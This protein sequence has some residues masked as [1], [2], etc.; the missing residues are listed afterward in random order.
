MKTRLF[1]VKLFALSMGIREVGTVSRFGENQYFTSPVLWE[2]EIGGRGDAA[3]QPC[4]FQFTNMNDYGKSYAYAKMEM[5]D[6]E[7]M[8]S[9]KA[10]FLIYK[11]LE[12]ADSSIKRSQKTSWLKV[13]IFKLKIKFG[14]KMK[15]LKK[16]LLVVSKCGATKVGVLQ[17]WKRLFTARQEM[18]KIT[19]VFSTI[20]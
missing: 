4:G 6:P 16:S 12:K 9:R 2:C 1:G 15:K 13:R 10:Q 8:K 7:E 20:Q 19:N 17:Q 18:L 5:E 11:S 3:E 14:K